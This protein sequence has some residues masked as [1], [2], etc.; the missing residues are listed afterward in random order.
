MMDD[1]LDAARQKKQADDEL[2]E[3]LRVQHQLEEIEAEG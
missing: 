3:R 2:A 1:S